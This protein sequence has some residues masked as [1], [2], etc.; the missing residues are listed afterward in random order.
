MSTSIYYNRYTNQAYTSSSLESAGM[1][2]N[3]AILKKAGIYPLED[4]IPSYDSLTQKVEKW[5]LPQL[6]PSGITFYQH[7]V[8]VELSDEEKQVKKQEAAKT[9]LAQVDRDTVRPLRA[10][11]NSEATEYD[12]KKLYDLECE[13]K[14]QRAIMAGQEVPAFHEYTPGMIPAKPTPTTEVVVEPTITTTEE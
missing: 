8:V 2:L 10:W 14:K 12:L 4:I 6:S 3:N 1:V 13:A 7:Y 5:G 11:L 9:A